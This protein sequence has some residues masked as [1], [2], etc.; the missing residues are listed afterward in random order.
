MGQQR[1]HVTKAAEKPWP[2]REMCQGYAGLAQGRDGDRDRVWV[3]QRN[4]HWRA[5]QMR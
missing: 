2:K 5:G 4:T 3:S 1:Q